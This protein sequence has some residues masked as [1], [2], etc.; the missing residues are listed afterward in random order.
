[1]I[2]ESSVGRVKI[3]GRRLIKAASAP[4]DEI[5]DIEKPL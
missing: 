4:P 5:S 2:P 1:V 3:L